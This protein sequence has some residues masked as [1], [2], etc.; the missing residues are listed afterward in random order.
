[1]SVMILGASGQVGRALELA[2]AAKEIRVWTYSHKQLDVSDL[3][4]VIAS[5]QSINPKVIINASAY[6]A[7]DRA[8]QH[9]KDAFLVNHLGV[10][11]IAT[12]A[13]ITGAAFVHISTD[14]VFDGDGNLPYEEGDR[15]SPINVY[16]ASKLAG[17]IEALAFK[18]SLVLRTSWVF[19][20]HGN[21]FVKTMLNIGAQRGS[22]SIVAD[23]YGG[24][25]Y[26]GD[27]AE[28]LVKISEKILTDGKVKWGVYNYSGFPY[29]SWYE[30]AEVIFETAHSLGIVSDVPKL[31]KVGSEFYK[32][33]AG[34]PKNSR[35]NNKKIGHEFDVSPSDWKRALMNIERFV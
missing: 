9:P 22:L 6:T 20:E 3:N 34:R 11:H 30:F 24:P 4:A 29:V 2:F 12:A 32:T 23:Q 17:E 16:G 13:D 1:M 33:L 10:K 14:Y 8:E 27:I 15:A 19:G 28:V 7:V 18:K 26:A 25:T 35:L 21:N 5:A 31:E